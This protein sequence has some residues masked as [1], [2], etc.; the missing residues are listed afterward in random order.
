MRC[1][2]VGEN[3]GNKW[4][5]NRLRGFAS[6]YTGKNGGLHGGRYLYADSRVTTDRRVGIKGFW[7]FTVNEACESRLDFAQCAA[8]GKFGQN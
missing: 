6:G 2:D 8:V 5:H 1:Q 4:F 3:R 7:A